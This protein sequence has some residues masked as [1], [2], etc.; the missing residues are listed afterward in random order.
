M[1][2]GL[3]LGL[4]FILAESYFLWGSAHLEMIPDLLGLVTCDITQF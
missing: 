4:G 2:F 1:F 3:Q